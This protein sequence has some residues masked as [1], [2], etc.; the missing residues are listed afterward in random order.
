M[1][2]SYGDVTPD[3]VFSSWDIKLRNAFQ[4]NFSGSEKK[5]TTIA[6]VFEA[7]FH[8]KSPDFI[9]ALNHFGYIHQFVC[10][11]LFPNIA[12][13]LRIITNIQPFLLQMQE[14]N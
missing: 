7:R 11:R 2:F 12:S 10:S 6:V 3:V 9:R 1:G 4:I 13:V 14:K 5:L 8:K